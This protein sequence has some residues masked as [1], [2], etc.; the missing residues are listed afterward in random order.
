MWIKE[1]KKGDHTN[2]RSE[3][4]AGEKIYEEAIS[5]A[6]EMGKVKIRLEKIESGGI[7]T[8]QQ[9]FQKGKI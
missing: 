1:H 9:Q 3:D 5:L 7:V 4:F 8:N 6:D 2:F